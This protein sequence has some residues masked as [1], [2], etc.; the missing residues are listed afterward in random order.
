M[1]SGVGQTLYFHHGAVFPF[2]RLTC[3][4][5]PREGRRIKPT[6]EWVW[7]TTLTT[8]RRTL[9]GSVEIVMRSPTLKACGATVTMS[10]I[11][12]RLP[13]HR[14]NLH[15]GHWVVSP[16]AGVELGLQEGPQPFDPS[17]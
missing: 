15:F 4:A 13:H 10:S 5:K 1:G 9:F 14:L 17:L 12:P 7:L 2:T 16:C 11:I 6:T 8:Q 3:R